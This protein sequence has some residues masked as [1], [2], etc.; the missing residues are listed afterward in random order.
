MAGGNITLSGAGSGATPPNSP[1]NYSLNGLA[2]GS[3]TVTPSLTAY[4]FT[5]TSRSVPL[6]GANQTSVNFTAT[7]TAYN[8]SRTIMLS[9]GGAAAGMDL[10]PSGA[11]HATTPPAA[12][13]ARP[14]GR[15]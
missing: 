13:G 5:P 7:G 3:Y 12:A 2:N 8:I 10:P 11:G 14:A 1:G 15:P 6:S 4:S 9:G